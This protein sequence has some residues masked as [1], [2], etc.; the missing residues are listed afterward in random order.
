[1]PIYDVECK[2]CGEIELD[3]WLKMDELPP[4]CKKCGGERIRHCGGRFKLVYNNQ[5]D[6][7]GWG[8]SGYESSQFWA[9]VK[10]ARDR[11]EK[12]KGAHEN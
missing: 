1:M 9:G 2:T 3:L 10:A 4:P 6:L 7:C 12:V 8:D 11:G 5:T